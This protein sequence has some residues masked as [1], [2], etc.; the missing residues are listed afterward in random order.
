MR[1]NVLTTDDL[2]WPLF[3]VDGA[4]TRRAGGFHARRAATFGRRGR[5]RR[6]ARRRAR[7]SLPGAVSLYR[8]QAT[9]RGRQR[10]AQS[11]QP[12][13]RAHGAIKQAVPEIGVLCDVA[14]DPYTSHGHD[15]LLR[16]GTIVNDETVV[17][18][19]PSW[20]KPRPAATSSRRR[21]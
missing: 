4:R 10:S 21:T 5:A 15:G 12:V 13:C 11:R 20:S 3:L 9:R 2:I 7:H 14:L 18:V 1:E 17:L 6:R 8:S 16:G 19:P